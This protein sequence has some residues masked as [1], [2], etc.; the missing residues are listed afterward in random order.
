[1]ATDLQKEFLTQ[2][3]TPFQKDIFEECLVHK[4]G[5]LSLTMG[6][7]KTIVSLAVSL[8][9]ANKEPVI[10]VVSKTLLSS[11]IE[12]IKKFYGDTLSF[13]VLHQDYIKKL[14]ELE[15]NNDTRVF[16]TTPEFLSKVYKDYNIEN[17]L[18]HRIAEAGGFEQTQYVSPMSPFLNVKIGLGVIFSIKWGAI[19]ID[20]IQ[21]YTKIT[22]V[23]GRA[24][25]SLYSK[26][27]WGL[28][29]TMFDEPTP[30]RIL[31]YHTM[32]NIRGF[33]RS[34]IE[35]SEF[36][37]SKRFKGIKRTLVFRDTNVSFI[38][39]KVNKYIIENTLTY[40]EN[41]MYMSV[42]D[43][44]KIISEK[45]KQFE[46]E[47]DIDNKR[48][49]GSYLLASICYLR[50]S[51]IS[52]IL[53]IAS[54]T[55]DMADLQS[56]SFLSKTLMEQFQKLNLVEYL[57]NRENV[58]STRI[59]SILEIVNKNNSNR[60]VLFSSFKSCLNLIQTFMP[61]TRSVLTIERW[62]SI[63]VRENVISEFRNTPNAILLLTYEIGS[64][65]LNLQ[66]SNTVLLTD[67]WW[68]TGKTDQAIARSLR[69]GQTAR[70]VNVYFFTS[71]TGIEK[72]I[73]EK[74]FEKIAIVKEIQTGPIVSK[75][76]KFKID[77]ILK[78]IKNE[79]TNE[80]LEKIIN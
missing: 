17:Y 61:K 70:E 51:V 68:N 78:I 54:A 56:K 37:K 52:C 58:M 28:S 69:Y 39:P 1:M 4:S 71:N 55:I 76:Q 57:E 34:L 65:G 62:M 79:E 2:K 50:Q 14:D 40:E 44:M 10:V 11:W 80:S 59:K 45:I 64:A 31:G 42:R 75:I 38:P 6:S 5:G 26:N 21:C 33:P 32:L 15:I 74:H 73:F 35:A 46:R 63:K 29:G 72:A 77:E 22:S 3:L 30:E 53:P 16:L 66:C 20:E 23:R 25:S 18:V 47:C 41:V 9:Q 8:F 67:F 36:V 13:K 49:F 24:I 27:R 48:L 60:I 19:V 43:T 12:E 7:G